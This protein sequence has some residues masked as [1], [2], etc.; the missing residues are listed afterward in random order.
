MEISELYKI[1]C[2]HPVVTTDTRDCPAGSI[3]F[4]LRGASFNGNEFASRAL[5]AGCS[6]AVV[7][8]PEVAATDSRMLRPSFR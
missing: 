8:E 3:F 7:D 1:F 5:E 2:S 4:A 6:Y